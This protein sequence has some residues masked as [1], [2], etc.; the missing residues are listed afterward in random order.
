MITAL[1]VAGALQFLSPVSAD[2]TPQAALTIH[3]SGRTTR[4]PIVRAP[5]GTTRAL[6]ADLVAN[7]LG[8]LVRR[9]TRG[10]YEMTVPGVTLYL[11]DREAFATTPTAVVPLPA[12]PYVRDGLLYLPFAIVTDVLPRVASGVIYD[13]ARAELRV[14]AALPPPDQRHTPSATASDVP[15]TSGDVLITDSTDI[16]PAAND[17]PTSRRKHLV[18]VDAGHGGPDHGMRGPLGGE[19]Q[20]DEKD[21]TLAVALKVGAALRERGI[22]AVQTRTSD[23]LIAL[24]DRGRIASAH[25]AELFISIHVNAANPAWRH[26][27]DARGFE[28]Y[29]LAEAK[30]EDARRVEQMENEAVRFETGPNASGRDPVNFIMKDMEQNQHLRQ[31]SVLAAVIQSHLGRVHPGPSRGVKQAGFRVLVTADMPAVLVEIGFGT[32]K[33]EARFLESAVGQ[34]RLAAAI[35]SAATEY[36]AHYDTRAMASMT[37]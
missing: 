8:G 37:Q 28:T 21:I 25:K 23:T 26:P 29:F 6:R 1:L 2:S 5:N 15:D 4:V 3:Y 17:P 7:A 20:V 16:V 35:A 18:V 24:D 11:R 12:V 34:R 19:P 30:T 10:H 32:N 27:R 22:D 33:P 31:S 36:F 9:M 13:S 14:F